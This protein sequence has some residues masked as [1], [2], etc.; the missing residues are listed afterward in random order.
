[1][2]ARGRVV[3]AVGNDRFTYFYEMPKNGISLGFMKGDVTRRSSVNHEMRTLWFRILPCILTQSPCGASGGGWVLTS[4]NTVLCY[5]NDTIWR[6]DDAA[7][8]SVQ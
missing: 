8:V 2:V 6:R 5:L 4:A 1:M 7:F 3:S